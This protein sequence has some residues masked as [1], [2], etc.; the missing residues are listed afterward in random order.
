M[1]VLEAIEVLRGDLDRTIESLEALRNGFALYAVAAPDLDRPFHPVQVAESEDRLKDF[2]AEKCRTGERL[3]IRASVL[4]G[5]YCRWCKLRGARPGGPAQ[6]TMRLMNAGYRYSRSRRIRG[7]Q[8]RTFE[9]IALR[10]STKHS[11]EVIQ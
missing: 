6:F 9:G 11:A 2:L 10:T 4:R 3:Y 5:A 7:L 1:N 8:Q